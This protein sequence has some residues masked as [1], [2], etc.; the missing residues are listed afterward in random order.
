MRVYGDTDDYQA[1]KVMF[2]LFGT[3][4][5]CLACWVLV[6]NAVSTGHYYAYTI[7]SEM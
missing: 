2:D 7:K 4:E 6:F 3:M 1:Q 5:T